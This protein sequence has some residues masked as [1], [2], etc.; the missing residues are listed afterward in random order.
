MADVPLVVISEFAQA[1]RRIT[2]SWSISQLK[3]KLETVTGVPPSCQRLSLKPTAGA[4]AIA[5]EAP[6]EDD[7]HLTN[8]PLAPYAELHVSQCVLHYST[9]SHLSDIHSC[10]LLPRY[11]RFPSTSDLCFLFV[12]TVTV[13]VPQVPGL[14]I[15]RSS[16]QRCFAELALNWSGEGGPSGRG[17]GR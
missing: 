1:E 6:N 14:V 8:F 2:P 17:G 7:T 13:T 4:E 12:V 9:A 10:I 11:S 5:I 15:F 3:T 16:L